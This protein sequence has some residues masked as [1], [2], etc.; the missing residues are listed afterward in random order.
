MAGMILL[1]NSEVGGATAAL[2]CILGGHLTAYTRLGVV[3]GDAVLAAGLSY[4]YRRL[5]SLIRGNTAETA[6]QQLT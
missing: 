5:A 1:V 2:I 3:V 4:Q 6:E